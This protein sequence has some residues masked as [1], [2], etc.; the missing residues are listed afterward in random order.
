M[1]YDLCMFADAHCAP[2]D[3]V[4]VVRDGWEVCYPFGGWMGFLIVPHGRGCVEGSNWD[5]I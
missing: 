2:R 4:G 3:Q 1:Q 5:Q